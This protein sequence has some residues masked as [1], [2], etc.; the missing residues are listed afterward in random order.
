M[1]AVGEATPSLPLGCVRLWKRTMSSGDNRFSAIRLMSEPVR[2]LALKMASLIISVQNT[3]SYRGIR[4][5][6]IPINHRGHDHWLHT[7]P[8]GSTEVRLAGRGSKERPWAR[9]QGEAIGDVGGFRTWAFCPP[10]EEGPHPEDPALGKITGS[11]QL[12]P[13]LASLNCRQVCRRKRTEFWVINS[14]RA[15]WPS[16]SSRASFL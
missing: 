10:K 6:T 16:L 1:E 8:N 7:P 3:L 5:M 13:R 2:R 4:K 11:P 15:A 12:L 9:E 14:H